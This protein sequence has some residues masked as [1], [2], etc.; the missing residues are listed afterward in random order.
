LESPWHV[1]IR[2]DNEETVET[3]EEANHKQMEL[4]DWFR[5]LFRDGFVKVVLHVCD[6]EEWY[7]VQKTSKVQDEVGVV[8]DS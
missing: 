3:D 6:E 8:G 5:H 4:P 2:E 7:I 1:G